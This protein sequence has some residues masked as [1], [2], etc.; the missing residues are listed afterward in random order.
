MEDFEVVFQCCTSKSQLLRL[1]NKFI[2]GSSFKNLEGLL[3]VLSGGVTAS[4]FRRSYYEFFQEDLIRVISGGVTMSSFRRSYYE[5]FQEGLL[6]V[7]SGGVTTSSFR[8]G[9]YEFFQDK[10]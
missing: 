8:R 2:S 10:Y 7:L 1:I 3:R 5:L 6:R 9:Y 4:S